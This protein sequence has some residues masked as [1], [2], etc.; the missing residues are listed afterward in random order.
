LKISRNAPGIAT[1]FNNAVLKLDQ[2]TRAGF[3]SST[4]L[5]VATYAK[6]AL[7]DLNYVF[8]KTD[9]PNL[10]LFFDASRQSGL[11]RTA[12]RGV[13]ERDVAISQARIYTSF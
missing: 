1:I 3:E 7:D 13:S 2:D 10:K 9:E 8:P 12:K 11:N 6:A 4:N 5:Q